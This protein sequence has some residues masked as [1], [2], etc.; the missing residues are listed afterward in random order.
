MTV[1]GN[2]ES[3]SLLHDQQSRVITRRM[4]KHRKYLEN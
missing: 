3:D 4:Q 1:Q 2:W